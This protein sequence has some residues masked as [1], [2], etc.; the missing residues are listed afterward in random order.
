MKENS[1]AKRRPGV[2][3]EKWGV[4][5]VSD[6]NFDGFCVYLSNDSRRPEM[7]QIGL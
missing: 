2:A 7:S 5:V 4:K 6:L 1:R 3:V